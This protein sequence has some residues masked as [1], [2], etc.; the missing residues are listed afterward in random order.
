[1]PKNCYNC[2]SRHNCTTPCSDITH[3]LQKPENKN[4]YSYKYMKRMEIPFDISTIEIIYLRTYN[5]H[6]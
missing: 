3:I 5:L 2:P 4:K 6:F 1:M